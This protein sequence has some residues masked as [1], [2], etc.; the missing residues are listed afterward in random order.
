MHMLGR[1]WHLATILCIGLAACMPGGSSRGGGGEQGSSGGR[2]GSSATGGAGGEGSGG[3]SAADGRGGS[4]GGAGS[5]GSGGSSGPAGGGSGGAGGAGG[6]STS[7]GG[8]GGGRADAG[9]G[10]RGGSAG[11]TG[12]GGRNTGGGTAAGGAGG[13]L[14]GAGGSGAL[15]ITGLK[16]EANPKNVL[17]C[18]VSWKTD[19]PADSAVQFGKSDYEWEIEDSKEVTE[20]RVLVIGMHAATAYKIKAVSKSSGGTASAEGTFTTGALPAT[21]PVAEVRALDKSKIQPGWTL[22]N[23]QKGDGT[24]TAKSQHPSQ[25]VMY[26][27]DGKPVWY[28]IHGKSVDRGGAI[29]VELTDKGVLLGSVLD[30]NAVSAEPPREV[31]FAGNTLWECSTPTCGGSGNLTHEVHKL[32]NG[33]YVIQRDVS[34]GSGTSPVYEEITA[35]GKVVWSL[36][37]KKLVTAPSGAMGDWCHGNSVTVDIEKNVVYANCRYMG[38][39]K[40]TYQNPTLQWHLPASYNAKNGGDMAFSPPSSQYSDTHDPEIHDDGTVLV[41]DNGGYSGVIGEEGNPRG[42]QSRALEYKI[43]EAAKTATLVWEFP[44]TFSV[45]SWYKTKFYLPFWGDADRLPNGNVLVTAGVRGTSV[46]SR[47]FEVTKADGKVVWEF[48]LPADFGVY[49]SERLPNPPLVRS[50]NP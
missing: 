9:P 34:S 49:R 17:S 6:A 22:M 8:A 10:G 14:D 13:T 21:I 44:G 15:S 42:Y 36:D 40:T 48:L 29:P 46:Q 26:D 7:S 41:F 27:A 2:A 45:D 32:P 1:P 18:F 12:S 39:I 25:A 28:Y 47:I 24:A 50:L 5:D 23:I 20:H 11:G 37:Y 33:H 19:E 38:L 4:G 31:D 30:A 35:D 16:V 3:S 43:D